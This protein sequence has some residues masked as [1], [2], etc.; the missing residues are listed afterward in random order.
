MSSDVTNITFML[1]QTEKC[2]QEFVMCKIEG[3][4][5]CGMSKHREGEIRQGRNER[6]RMDWI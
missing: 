5:M 4:G 2:T 1:S 6:K 3:E